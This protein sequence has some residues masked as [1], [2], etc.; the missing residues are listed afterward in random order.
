MAG[1]RRRY[2]T[3][4]TTDAPCYLTAAARELFTAPMGIAFAPSRIGLIFER[5]NAF[6]KAGP[7][8]KNRPDPFARFLHRCL[9]ANR[10]Q[11]NLS[12]RPQAAEAKSPR[13]KI[14]P[15]PVTR[16]DGVNC[17]KIY[18][19]MTR[20]VTGHTYTRSSPSRAHMSSFCR[21]NIYKHQHRHRP[22]TNDTRNN[23]GTTNSPRHHLPHDKSG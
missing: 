11:D 9:P 19:Q 10:G 8:S 2:T 5:G 13:P 16:P 6:R 22:T 7:G 3:V 1:K 14:A 4:C 18:L 17:D 23:K 15:T 21:A 20:L 12:G